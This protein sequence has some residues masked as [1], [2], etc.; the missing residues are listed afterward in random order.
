MHRPIRTLRYLGP[1]VLSASLVGCYD[2]AAQLDDN[3]RTDFSQHIVPLSEITSG[4]P[5]YDYF[6]S[7]MPDNPHVRYFESR[8]P[9]YIVCD[10]NRDRWRTDFYAVVTDV[11]DNPKQNLLAS[12][13]VKAGK[14][15]PEPV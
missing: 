2:A 13:R 4:G 7:L 3:W 10:V 9:G 15:G 11:T 8:L 5:P 12:Y 1:L 14:P 6:T